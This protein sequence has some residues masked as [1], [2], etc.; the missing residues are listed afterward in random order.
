MMERAFQG[1]QAIE[2]LKPERPGS[3]LCLAQDVMR[4]PA[5]RLAINSLAATTPTTARSPTQR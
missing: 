2:G 4:A 3:V 1:F 5:V